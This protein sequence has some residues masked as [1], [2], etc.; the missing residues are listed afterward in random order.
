M[1][2]PSGEKVADHFERQGW[3]RTDV[4]QGTITMQG[5]GG[6]AGREIKISQGSD[7]VKMGWNVQA[8]R[9]VVVYNRDGNIQYRNPDVSP[10]FQTAGRWT[11]E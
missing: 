4:S 1:Y 10:D 7:S 8:D 2:V 5:S 6:M 3:T 9:H 11:H